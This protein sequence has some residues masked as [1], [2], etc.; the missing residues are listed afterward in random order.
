MDSIVNGD[1]IVVRD[2]RVVQEITAHNV[3]EATLQIVEDGALYCRVYESPP[4]GI[5]A[6]SWQEILDTPLPGVKP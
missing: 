4:E 6:E 3:A 2:R 1:Y 5:P